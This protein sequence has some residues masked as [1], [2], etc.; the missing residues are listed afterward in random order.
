MGWLE[1]LIVSMLPISEL[2]GAIP[3]AFALGFDPLSAFI[4]ATIGNF[5]PVPAILFT[6]GKLERLI[7]RSPVIGKIYRHALNLAY[8]RRERVERYGYF[9]LTF[10]VAI[11][12]PV[13]G[14]WTGSLIAFIL[15]LDRLK[16][17]LFILLGIIVA[18]ITV[19]LATYGI[20]IIIFG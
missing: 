13:T 19:T 2:R 9:G 7:E 16:S 10:F 3:L 5:I 12:F 18:G 17:L 14:A 11:P 8:A 20:K 4:T 1:V 6:L 15:G